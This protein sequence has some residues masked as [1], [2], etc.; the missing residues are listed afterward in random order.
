MYPRPTCPRFTHP[1]WNNTP[2]DSDSSDNAPIYALLS[3][4]ERRSYLQYYQDELDCFDTYFLAE[5]P[6]R[7]NG[8]S[9]MARQSAEGVAVIAEIAHNIVSA[10]ISCPVNLCAYPLVGLSK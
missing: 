1:L 4:Q 3:Y 8:S 7:S 5:I 6:G 10:T 2:E 9:D